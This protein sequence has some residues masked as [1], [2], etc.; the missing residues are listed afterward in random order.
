VLASYNKA[1]S[2]KISTDSNVTM[3]LK[4]LNYF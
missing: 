4:M 2:G 1:V 3:A